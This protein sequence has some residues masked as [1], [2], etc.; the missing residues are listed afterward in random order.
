MLGYGICPKKAPN[1]IVTVPLE[2]RPRQIL[3]DLQRLAS[4]EWEPETKVKI[5]PVLQMGR[6]KQFELYGPAANLDGAV[7]VI[8]KWLE[9][10]NKKAPPSLAWSKTKAFD[11]NDWY[12]EEVKNM[13]LVRK[14]AFK[15]PIPEGEMGNIPHRILIDWPDKLLELEPKVTPRD[16]FGNK[17]EALDQ[18]R[19]EEEVY[20]SLIQVPHRTAA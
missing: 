17:L 2:M 7:K 13:E 12:Y 20:I 10:A 8:N 3:V 11:F 18:L 4:Q 6:L 1:R 9:S 15:K 19:M 16:A 5:V 14:E